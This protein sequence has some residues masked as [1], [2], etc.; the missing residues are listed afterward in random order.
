MSERCMP[1]IVLNLGAEMIYVLHQRLTAQRVAPP[2]VG[3]IIRTMV[4]TLTHPEFLGQ[5]SKPQEVYGWAPTIAV[6]E[7]LCMA[8]SISLNEESFS[9]LY[10]M[11]IMAFKH[12]VINSTCPSYLFSA[13]LNHLRGM[14]DLV[15]SVDSEGETVGHLQAA[16]RLVAREYG[17]L[18]QGEWLLIR[19]TLLAFVQTQRSKIA[20]L[21]SKGCQNRE[22]WITVPPG[23]PVPVGSAVPGLITE[24]HPGSPTQT[25]FFNY[26]HP[27][28]D[29]PRERDPQTGAIETLLGRNTLIE[30]A[31]IAP[32]YHEAIAD[33]GRVQGE[34]D[35]GVASLADLPAQLATTGADAVWGTVTRASPSH[36]DDPPM[37]TV[38]PGSAATT[39]TTTRSDG[40][41]PDTDRPPDA[42]QG[43]KLL[44][45]LIG[46]RRVSEDD[47]FKLSLSFTADADAAVP[48]GRGAAETASAGSA[49]SAARSSS[50]GTTQHSVNKL[51]SRP[52]AS[53]L[54][55]MA[56][57]DEV[58]GSAAPAVS[59]DESLLDLLDMV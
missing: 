32:A 38:E 15:V 56:D 21:M 25:R 24:F 29:A 23:G 47:G 34:S 46:V 27:C 5:L 3:R 14:R 53:M 58:V 30:D 36:P 6:F 20:V 48:G 22:G 18:S 12:Q 2:D 54:K 9:K 10:D 8:S 49:G 11:M 44:S 28:A 51:P 57:F 1:L 39:T 42:P 50:G 45:K 13:T 59:P 52:S 33:E 17:A 26:G 37:Y 31:G 4:D 35:T 7:R 41:S 16:E 40:A 55:I 43:L 19:Q